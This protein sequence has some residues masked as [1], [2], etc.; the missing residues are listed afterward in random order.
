MKFT[1][2][3]LSL[4]LAVSAMPN[5]VSRREKAEL[6][7]RQMSVGTATDVCG[8][9]GTDLS[10]CNE[11]DDGDK[12]AVSGVGGGL[13]SGVLSNIFGTDGISVLN[14]CAKIS[15]VGRT[16]SFASASTFAFHL[17]GRPTPC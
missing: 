16:S 4:A 15:V 8:N 9:V 12:T 2:A 1:L 7:V 13:I 6:H 5:A 10:C 11:G 17:G 3:T 14:G